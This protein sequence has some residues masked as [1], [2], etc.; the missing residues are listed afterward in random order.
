MELGIDPR[1][2]RES[3]GLGDV[4]LDDPEARIPFDTEHAV[5]AGAMQATGDATL[6]LRAARHVRGEDYR[7]LLW[8]GRHSPTVGEA[9]SRVARWFALV[10]RQARFVV[11]DSGAPALCFEV[12]GLPPPLPRPMVDYS[13]AVTFLRMR[14]ATGHLPLL[15]VDV[16][17]AAPDDEAAE[18]LFGCP[19]QHRAPR[20]ALVLAC[21]DWNHPVP[22]AD[23]ALSRNLEEHAAMLLEKVPVASTFR[24]DVERVIASALPDGA[25]SVDD[26]GRALGMSGR[27]LQRRL[28]DDGLTWSRL[29]DDVRLRLA[30]MHL[31][32][33]GISIAEV[34]FLLGFSEQSAFTR[35]FK[36][37]TGETPAAS[38]RHP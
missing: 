15:R 36:R 24:D 7:V 34:A 4:D 25:P 17:Y 32:D 26:A 19:V 31:A 22:G 35:A 23:A 5:W 1:P 30:R 21:A 12:P 37:W 11:D 6:P 29:V 3:A 10:N 27:S 33:P 16:P 9:L 8:L 13:L 18:T 20:A 38:R 14:I 2:L 28:R